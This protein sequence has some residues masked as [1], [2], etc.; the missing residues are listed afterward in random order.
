MK[1]WNSSLEQKTPLKAKTSLKSRTRL[2]SNGF[3]LKQTP[4]RKVSDKQKAELRLR[5]KIKSQLIKE[6]PKDSRGIV[7]CS[8]CGRPV[9]WDWRSCKGGDL[10]HELSLGRGGK[11][12]KE[13]S[14][15]RCRH[16]H[17][18]RHGVREIIY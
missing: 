6:A 12:T 10:S 9:D 1:R 13:N 15:I 14:A 17:N 2:K 5:A 11:T 8:E 18:K 3:H 7:L 16:C 4:L